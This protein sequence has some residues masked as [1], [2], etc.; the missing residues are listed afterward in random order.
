M[1]QSESMIQSSSSSTITHHQNTYSHTTGHITDTT[2][3]LQ[4]TSEALSSRKN[5]S[6][7]SIPHAA[8]SIQSDHQSQP[9]LSDHHHTSSPTHTNHASLS[10]PPSPS[11]SVLLDAPTDA[12]LINTSLP[13][14]DMDAA[15]LQSTPNHSN[16]PSSAAIIPSSIPSIPTKCQGF[17]GF[18]GCNFPIVSVCNSSNIDIDSTCTSDDLLYSTRLSRPAHN[19]ILLSDVTQ[20]HLE[21]FNTAASSSSSASASASIIES[22]N[23]NFTNPDPI[24][25]VGHIISSSSLPLLPSTN[26]SI[27][28]NVSDEQYERKSNDQNPASSSSS[29]PTNP[30]SFTP[31]QTK[32][33]TML[34][35]IPKYIPSS[36]SAS[37]S[38]SS[39]PRRINMDC[40]CLVVDPTLLK[41]DTND[42]IQHDKS[43]IIP[44]DEILPH[45]KIWLHEIDS[46]SIGE[47]YVGQD[48]LL[49]I[50]FT[51]QAALGIALLKYQFLVRCIT[52][53]M[54]QTTEW[55][56]NYTTLQQ[57]ASS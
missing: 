9:F 55:Y 16:H 38:S 53:S 22:T 41:I 6:N 19:N 46:A 30:I 11:T 51:T 48:K 54:E 39:P 29:H 35:S 31:L 34:A 20:P 44:D 13:N 37:S 3:T 2:N 1:S 10:T 17:L 43:L 8:A 40:Q 23:S 52:K 42:K 25:L 4:H 5:D 47:A 12:N 32:F 27:R 28:P 56:S 24:P 33:N 49:H 50:N 15:Q 45:V 14:F 57:Q 36:A 21:L 26:N 7:N 18:S